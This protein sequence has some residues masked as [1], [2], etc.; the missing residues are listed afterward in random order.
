MSSERKH[1]FDLSVWEWVVVALKGSLAVVLA[2]ILVIIALAVTLLPI[3]A[4]V[5]Q[6]LRGISGG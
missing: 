3:A 4:G 2:T 5:V 1:S 6:Q